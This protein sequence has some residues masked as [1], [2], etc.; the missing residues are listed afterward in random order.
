[1]GRRVH[2]IMETALTITIRSRRCSGVA[3]ATHDNVVRDSGAIAAAAR[4]ESAGS[5]PRHDQRSAITAT[6]NVS[7]MA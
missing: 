7:V 1:M 5:A 3:T 6:I 4:G 2:P